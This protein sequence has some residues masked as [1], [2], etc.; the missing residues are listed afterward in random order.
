MLIARLGAE[1]QVDFSSQILGELKQMARSEYIAFAFCLPL[2]L[3]AEV[4]SGGA[5]GNNLGYLGKRLTFLLERRNQGG[6]ILIIP[7][8]K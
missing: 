3:L 2:L 8:S 7:T 4:F 6:E 5:M 1:R